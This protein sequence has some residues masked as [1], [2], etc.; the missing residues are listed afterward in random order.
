MNRDQYLSKRHRLYGDAPV[1]AAAASGRVPA[2]PPASPGAGRH[3]PAAAA[4]AASP[5]ASALP[6]RYG[7]AT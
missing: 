7:R 4:A 1:P 2:L 6:P 3:P 5:S